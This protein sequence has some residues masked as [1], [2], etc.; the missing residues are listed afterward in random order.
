MA[1]SCPSCGATGVQP[2]RCRICGWALFEPSP[3]PT[4]V[5]AHENA[6][7]A[8]KIGEVL[9]RAGFTA[10]AVPTGSRAL[11]LLNRSAAYVL[12]VGLATDLMAFQVIDRI[13]AM[14][15]GEDVPVVLVAS[16]Y[17][18]T[19]YKR[20]PSALYGANDY[21]EQHHITDM[22][23]A[24]LCTLLGID[25]AGVSELM[26]D[27]E[28]AEFNERLA[29]VD[30]AVVDAAHSIVADIALYHQ[31]DFEQAAEGRETETLRDALVEGSRML[32]ERAGIDAGAAMKPLR[33]AFDAFV[34][35]LQ[36]ER[37]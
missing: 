28:T 24:K 2:P 30:T 15:N 5:I 4:V 21:V 13:R 17:N 18:K 36:R 8:H 6:D 22:L 25:P 14:A 7:V 34:A 33:R 16:V 32:A 10:V 20:R 27:R 3:G 29:A 1:S 12:D 11:A 37:R 19:A 9:A 35:D 23:P 31:S 26:S